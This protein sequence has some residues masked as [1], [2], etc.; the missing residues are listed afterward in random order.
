MR[1]FNHLLLFWRFSFCFLKSSNCLSLPSLNFD[2]QITLGSRLK[3][4]K[5][6]KKHNINPGIHLA[7]GRRSKQAAAAWLNASD[8]YFFLYP[9]HWEPRFCEN[10]SHRVS[11]DYNRRRS[12]SLMP[13]SPWM[14]LLGRQVNKGSL[15]RQVRDETEAK[16]WGRIGSRCRR[17]EGIGRAASTYTGQGTRPQGVALARGALGQ[18]LVPW[19]G[20]FSV[21]WLDG[22]QDYNLHCK[23]PKCWKLELKTCLF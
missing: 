15:K 9:C 19:W 4:P 6:K 22:D 16:G 20:A 21:V 13:L 18:S 3:Q 11:W 1:Y 5:K 2:L 14:W 10:M 8:Y 12:P 17:Q 23:W 7:F